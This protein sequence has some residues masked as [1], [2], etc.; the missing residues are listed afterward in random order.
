MR[1]PIVS[2]GALII[3]IGFILALVAMSGAD[4]RGLIGVR[5]TVVPKPTPSEQTTFTP[6]GYCD[7]VGCTPMGPYLNQP[8][9]V[10]SK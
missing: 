10:P 9:A 6:L 7:K 8:S 3:A 5:Y 2:V 1:I 4:G